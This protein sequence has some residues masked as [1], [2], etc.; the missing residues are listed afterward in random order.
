MTRSTLVTS[1]IYVLFTIL[2]AFVL[3]FFL[4]WSA[5]F[6]GAAETKC[7]DPRQPCRILTLTPEE[8]TALTGPNMILQSAEQGRFL[9][10]SSAVKYFRDKIRAAPLVQPEISE[11]KAEQSLTPPGVQPK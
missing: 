10:L 5:N 7:S 3:L 1:F 9:D 2:A 8:E 6:I 4:L 11:P